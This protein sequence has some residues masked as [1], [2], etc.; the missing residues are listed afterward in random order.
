MTLYKLV[1]HDTGNNSTNYEVNMARTRLESPVQKVAIYSVAFVI[2][3]VIICL[4]FFK[5]RQ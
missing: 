4:C 2:E 1:S 5:R 3:C